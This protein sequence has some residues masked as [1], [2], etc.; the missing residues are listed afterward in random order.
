MCWPLPTCA[1]RVRVEELADSAPVA[2]DQW[3]LR[4]RL[5]GD[6]YL[7]FR[8]LLSAEEVRSAGRA[9]LAWLRDGGWVDDRAIPSIQPR[10]ADLG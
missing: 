6:G 2:D 1:Y 4:H 5:A 7:F 10:P 9:V 8:G 3:E